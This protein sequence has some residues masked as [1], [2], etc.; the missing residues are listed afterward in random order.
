VSEDVFPDTHE[1]FHIV[2]GQFVTAVTTDPTKYGLVAADITALQALQTTYVTAHNEEIDA[3]KIAHTKT[4][5][6][7]TAHHDYLTSLRAAARRVH[8]HVGITLADLTAA[9]LKPHDAVKHHL[10][11][12]TTRPLGHIAE[13]GPLHQELHWVDETTPHK[14]AKPHGIH[15]CE[16]WL[17][18]GDPAPVDD[19][20][21]HLVATDTKT[22]Y[23]YAFE[24]ADAG[25][26]AYCCFDG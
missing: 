1:Q 25:K 12:P 13:H 6:F 10:G 24:P 8:G 5:A 7:N 19:T 22:P 4:K 16:L 9:G 11:T 21:A 20:T 17:K 3:K 23:V 26:T 2:Q 15:A 18:I 14:R